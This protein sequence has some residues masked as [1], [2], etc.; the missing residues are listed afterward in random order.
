MLLYPDAA[1]DARVVLIERP[2]GDGHHSGEVSFPGGKAEPD[3]AD[4]VAT[5][6]REAAE[7]VGL[8]P[9]AAGVRIVGQLDRFWIPV[10]D[11]E[12]TPV[13][14]LAE[15][16]PV[17]VADAGRGRPHPR[18]AARDVPPRR[19]DRDRRADDRRLAAALRRLRVDGL[20]VWGA[21]ARVLEPARRRPRAHDPRA[22]VEERR[23]RE[24]RPARRRRGGPTAHW[25]R[26]LRDLWAR[27]AGLTQATGRPA[28]R[29]P[30]GRLR[31]AQADPVPG[32]VALVVVACGRP[33]SD[34]DPDRCHRRTDHPAPRPRPSPGNPPATPYDG[35]TYDDPGVNP[36]VDPDEDRVSTFALDVDTASYSIAQRYVADGYRPDPAS[37]RVEEWVNAFE[38]DY[39]TPEDDAFAIHIDGGPTPF[40]D[41]DEILL[42][43]G[44]RAR[45]VRDR[46]RDDAA[47][48]FV[49]DTSG[50]ME[51][52][53]TARDG[54]GRAA[55]RSSTG[56]A[57]AT[58]SR[59]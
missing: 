44:L 2:T 40:T 42:R 4:V 59:S 34:V 55:H 8:D 15:R 51:T 41:D 16:R 35:V 33:A 24:P 54:Q 5:A 37:V 29:L 19:P 18:A 39:P 38:H 50:S 57:R 22:V 11:F 25:W 1:G 10:S 58:P 26:P 14:A 13:V 53:G 30:A 32:A 47:L 20:S 28:R 31:H 9:D 23:Q 48:T 52:R 21:T 43:I 27:L 56:S 6:L 17:L 45:D 7:E 12:V 49:I 3:D 46:A 36:Y